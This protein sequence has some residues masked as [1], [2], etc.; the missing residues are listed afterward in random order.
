MKKIKIKES[1]IVKLVKKLVKESQLLNEAKKCDTRNNNPYTGVNSSCGAGPGGGSQTCTANFPGNGYDG[2]CGPMGGMTG[3]PT[4]GGP[5]LDMDDLDKSELGGG[6]GK[7]KPKGKPYKG[8]RAMSNDTMED[9]YGKPYRKLTARDIQENSKYRYAPMSEIEDADGYCTKHLCKVLRKWCG[10]DNLDADC[11]NCVCIPKGGMTPT[12]N[13]K[14][15]IGKGLPKKMRK[16]MEEI[17]VI[18]NKK[19]GYTN[20][21]RKYGNTGMEDPF[22]NSPN[23]GVA[24]EGNME[25]ECT[26]CKGEGCDHCNGLGY[27]LMEDKRSLVNEGFICPCGGSTGSGTGPGGGLGGLTYCNNSTGGCAE[28]CEGENQISVDDDRITRTTRKIVRTTM[29]P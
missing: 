9:N 6:R 17:A 4:G 7:D 5:V 13:G 23:Y 27:H 14:K 16:K 15:K 18:Q 10:E 3:T 12:A 21:E 19:N 25:R 11:R 28:C 8:G 29:I 22:R 24:Q 20:P 26:K 2:E 1:D